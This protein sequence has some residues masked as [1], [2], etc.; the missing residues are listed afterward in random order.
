MRFEEMTAPQIREVDRAN[1]LVLMPIAATEQHGPHCPTGTDTI[2]CGSIAAAVEQERSKNVLLLPTLWLGASQHHLRYGAT[3]TA[4]L[5][6]Y[7]TM[8]EEIAT[9]LLDDGFQRLMILNGHGGNIDPLRVALRNLQ[10]RYNNALLCGESYWDVA[11]EH[12]AG[13]LKGGAA[14]IGHA[15]EAETAL[16]MHL[17][18]GLVDESALV[19]CGQHLP[20]V[21]EGIYMARDMMQRTGN[22]ATGRPDL[23]SAE[24]GKLLF[25]GIVENVVGAIDHALK[26]PIP[27]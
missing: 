27:E 14:G 8:L 6:N 16:I 5:P 10:P 4:T 17:R 25:D 22:G 1:T 13:Q 9:P 2:I 19:D 12:I 20:D 15:C 24:Q 11:R 26:T 18:P 3:L 7:I 23:S 21:D